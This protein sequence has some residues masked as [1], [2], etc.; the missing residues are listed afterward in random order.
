MLQSV[1]FESGI[2]KTQQFEPTPVVV[3]SACGHYERQSDKH[4]PLFHL[5]TSPR[6]QNMVGIH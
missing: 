3:N 1:E 2:T 4:I 5:K 6:F